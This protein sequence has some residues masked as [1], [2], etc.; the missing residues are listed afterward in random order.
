MPRK[1]GEQGAVIPLVYLSKPTLLLCGD[2]IEE[3]HEHRQID[4]LPGYLG[5]RGRRSVT[6]TS[7]WDGGLQKERGVY[8]LEVEQTLVTS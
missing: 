2:H 1:D 4:Q 7:R 8:L 3:N 5:V 6:W